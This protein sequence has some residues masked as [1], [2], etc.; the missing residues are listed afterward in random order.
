MVLMKSFKHRYSVLKKGKEVSDLL[1]HVKLLN[2]TMTI[3][4]SLVATLTGR[5]FV[6]VMEAHDIW[7]VN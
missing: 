7:D 4:S 2:P 1:C 3:T 5:S 6:T